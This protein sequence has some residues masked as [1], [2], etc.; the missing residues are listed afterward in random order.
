MLWNCTLCS[1]A[2]SDLQSILAGQLLQRKVSITNPITV[3]SQCDNVQWQAMKGAQNKAVSV[4]VLVSW[5]ASEYLWYSQAELMLKLPKPSLLPL[6]SIRA[7]RCLNLRAT[8]DEICFQ[9]VRI[10][11]PMS[12]TS[13]L[14]PSKRPTLFPGRLAPNIGA[15][16]WNLA[17]KCWWRGGEIITLS[18]SVLTAFEGCTH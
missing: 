4:L 5:N 8:L 16:Q 10:T 15:E 12:S 7:R 14:G 17:V 3:Y 6:S 11:F 18:H 1:I 13:M 2:I 9:S